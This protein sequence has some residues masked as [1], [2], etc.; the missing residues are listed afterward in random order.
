MYNNAQYCS[1]IYGLKE[2]QASSY[3]SQTRRSKDGSDDE[4]TGARSSNEESLPIEDKVIHK[5]ERL[6]V[7]KAHGNVFS[8]DEGGDTDKMSAK[9]KRRCHH[10]LEEVQNLMLDSE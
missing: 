8:S 7:C 3:P 6:R 2:D 4:Q 10:D 9:E 5:A 1:E